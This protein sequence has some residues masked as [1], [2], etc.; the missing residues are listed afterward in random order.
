MRVCEEVSKDMAQ[1]PHAT[2]SLAKGKVAGLD[3]T[4]AAAAPR[5]K[6][7]PHPAPATPRLSPLAQ[8]TQPVAGHSAPLISLPSGNLLGP[9]DEA[10]DPE[11]PSGHSATRATEPLP[12]LA[13]ARGVVALDFQEAARVEST[14]LVVEEEVVLLRGLR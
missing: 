14:E 9:D 8:R 7:Q 3:H 12:Q 5:T 13:D 2:A 1:S 11:T 4:T 10:S 6:H